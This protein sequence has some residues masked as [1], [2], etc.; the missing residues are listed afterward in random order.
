MLRKHYHFYHR[1]HYFSRYLPL[2]QNFLR[3]YNCGQSLSHAESGGSQMKK[4]RLVFIVAAL[5]ALTGCALIMGFIDQ[6][7]IAAFTTTPSSGALVG[8]QITLNASTSTDPQGYTLEYSWTLTG[9]TESTAALNEA[10]LF[11]ATFTPDVAGDYVVNLQVNA[12]SSSKKSAQTSENISVAAPTVTAY[13]VTYDG[14]GNTGGAVPSDTTSYQ[15]GATVT[16]LG[17]TGNLVRAGYSFAGWNTLS[18]G[19][20]TTYAQGNTFP[21]GAISV[22]LYAKWTAGS[23]VLGVSLNKSSTTIQVGNAEQLSATVLPIDAT[24]K[25]VIWSS[26]NASVASVSTSGLVTAVSVG[27]ATIT[28]TTS[29]GGYSANVDISVEDHIY[30]EVLLSSPENKYYETLPTLIYSSANYDIIETYLNGNLISITNNSLISSA[31]A[32]FNTVMVNATRSSGNST[33]ISV[34]FFMN[35]LPLSASDDFNRADNTIIGNG[36]EEF[37]QYN[38]AADM[39]IRDG[40]LIVEGASNLDSFVDIVKPYSPTIYTEIILKSRVVNIVNDN[41]WTGIGMIGD[42]QALLTL[43]QKV[44][45]KYTLSLIDS[46]SIGGNVEILAQTP[47][48]FYLDLSSS[49]QIIFYRSNNSYYVF[50]IDENKF[51]LERE[52]RLNYD[53]YNG[54]SG[55]THIGLLSH[56]YDDTSSTQSLVEI[57]DFTYYK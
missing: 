32:G 11:S 6:P 46:D 33:T 48:T 10:I 17:N 37:S 39:K 44:G 42:H 51:I 54:I 21:I 7:P 38:G 9:P 36:W 14:N 24:N 41:A 5:V 3:A 20:G 8:S 13:T 57:D 26:S 1:Y 27:S 30:P 34:T 53:S 55:F 23:P 19:S 18:N 25:A 16:V 40:K 31:I 35:D 28:V 52:E 2:V 56:P 4:I 12:T 15:Q 22:A 43:L 29:D 50:L 49:I 45:T 47:E